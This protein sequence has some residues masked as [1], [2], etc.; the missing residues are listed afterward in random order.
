MRLSALTTLFLV[1][2]ISGSLYSQARLVFQNNPY[3]VINDGAYLVID[4]PNT[5]AITNPAQGNIVS[6]GEFNYVKWNIGTLAGTYQVPLTTAN[7]DKI[8]LTVSI[9]NAG[10]GGSN[11]HFLFSTYGGLGSG[12]WVSFDNR[13]SPVIHTMD[14]ATGSVENSAFVIDRFWIIDAA[15]YGTKPN[16]T[17]SIGYADQEHQAT[18]N[19]ITPPSLGAQRYNSD[20][21]IWGD[22]LP[23]GTADITNRV[24]QNAPAD[25]AN[26]Y[27]VW[28][29][30]SKEMP[31]PVELINFE[32]V[33]N[34]GVMHV[35]WATASEH[36][37]DYFVLERSADA[38]NWTHVG[39]IQGNGNSSVVINYET[40]DY[41]P[42]AETTYYRLIQT[43]FNGQ[44]RN[45]GPI[46]ASCGDFQ[47]DILNVYNNFNSNQLLMNVS[48]SIDSNFEL[49]IS[50]MSGKI[51]HGQS[52]VAIRNGMNQ[53]K[54]SK[55]E[56]SMGIYII[57]L[58]NDQHL[59]TKKV[60]I[61]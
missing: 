30:T 13:P 6:E 1:L 59:L 43:D 19:T 34:H 42:F 23:Q 11:Q 14:I 51:I 12:P 58:V 9:N 46:A 16:A 24:V 33:C 52:G 28:T 2:I 8:P 26:F 60:A 20:E 56:M 37:N 50:D 61:N 17:L 27:K 48:S 35:K 44:S 15:G 45:Y 55:N 41:S 53:V 4:N 31:L 32:A 7:N 18:G 54:I 40:R 47:L 49:Y 36:N 3:V 25:P 5:N 39:Q 57:Q 21:H 29:L 10:T 22:Y 38:M